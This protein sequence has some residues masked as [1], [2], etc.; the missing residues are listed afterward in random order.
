MN[1]YQRESPTT[2][3]PPK[4]SLPVAELRDVVSETLFRMHADHSQPQPTET[5]FAAMVA[6]W[7]DHLQKAGVT[8]Y[9]VPAVYD[10]ALQTLAG[11]PKRRGFMPTIEDLLHE[12]D[13]LQSDELRKHQANEWK[14][15]DEQRRALPA[16]GDGPG[17]RAALEHMKLGHA[18]CCDCPPVRGFDHAAQ[19]NDGSTAWVCHQPAQ[20]GFYLPVTETAKARVPR[21]GP[22]S[23]AVTIPRSSMA[24]V[25]DLPKAKTEY[26]DDELLSELMQRCGFGI[27]KIGRERALQFARHLLKTA[28]VDLWTQAIARNTWRRYAEAA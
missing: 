8:W 17:R 7:M 2:M 1:D 23:S 21:G 9:D 6:S 26:S 25:R 18:V 3:L 20:C 22:L 19:L 4:D 27:D 16:G 11:N 10:N 15:S 24:P 12:W 13:V 5:Y 14:A 28:P